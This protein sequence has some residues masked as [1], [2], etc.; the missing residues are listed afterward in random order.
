MPAT[1]IHVDTDQPV[2]VLE[3]IVVADETF[4]RSRQQ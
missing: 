2:V 4:A 3:R 1:D